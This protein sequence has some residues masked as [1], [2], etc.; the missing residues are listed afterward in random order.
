MSQ[1]IRRSEDCGMGGK[2]SFLWRIFM[3]LRRPEKSRKHFHWSKKCASQTGEALFKCA[4]GG[5]IVRSFRD[6]TG[7]T[8]PKTIDNVSQLMVSWQLHRV[9]SNCHSIV[10]RETTVMMVKNREQRSITSRTWLWRGPPDAAC[11]KGITVNDARKTDSESRPRLGKVMV[12]E[13][14]DG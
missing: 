1:K 6:S 13:Q 12:I 11:T 5:F 3:C 8:R 4:R 10:L 9:N 2:R 14:K 7:R